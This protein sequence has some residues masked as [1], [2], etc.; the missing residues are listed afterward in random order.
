MDT[1]SPPLSNV[2]LELL[3]VFAYQ[4]SDE[5]LL[6]LKDTL[7]NFFAKKAIQSANEAWDKQGW[8]NQ[9]V[10]QLLRIHSPLSTLTQ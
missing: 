2:Q 6:E 7:A 9:K 1:S 5:D 8:D 3:K 10:D 4:V